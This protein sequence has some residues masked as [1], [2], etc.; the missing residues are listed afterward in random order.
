MLGELPSADSRTRVE[1]WER[2]GEDGSTLLDLVEYSWGSGLGWYVQKRM[3]L[4]G[5]QAQALRSILA[6]AVTAP[7]T[8]RLIQPRPPVQRDGNVVRLVF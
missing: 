6:P 4:D 8:P 2:T 1:L 3:T 5:A 7:P